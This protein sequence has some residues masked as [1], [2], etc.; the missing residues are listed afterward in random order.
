MN[1]LWYVMRCALL[2]AMLS[3]PVMAQP[4]TWDGGQAQATGDTADP[5]TAPTSRL[6]SDVLALIDAYQQMLDE[7]QQ[8]M[9]VDDLSLL[10]PLTALSEAYLSIGNYREAEIHL[11]QQV[12]LQRMALGLYHANQ[13]PALESLL[14]LHALR[15]DWTELS[16]NLAHIQWLYSRADM[17]ADDRLQGLRRLRGWL[18]LL[19]S[20][21]IQERESIHLLAYHKLSEQIWETALTLYDADDDQLMPWLY[22]LSNAELMIALTIMTNPLAGQDIIAR[23]EGIRDQGV[24]PGQPIATIADLEMAYG[25]RV[26]TV[27]ERSFRSHMH[28]HFQRLDEIRE[29]YGESGNLEAEAIMLIHLGDSVLI[30][31][32]FEG[33]PGSIAGPRRGS[34]AP[35]TAVRYYRDAYKMFLE[36]GTDE[37]TFSRYFGCPAIL[38]IDE[39]HISLDQM[40]P[41][42]QRAEDGYLVLPDTQFIGR[43]IPGVSALPMTDVVP[44][45][46]DTMKSAVA[47]F[48]IARNGHATQIRALEA[49]DTET[50]SERAAARRMISDMQFRPALHQG[51][52]VATEQVRMSFHLP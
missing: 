16:D 15:R 1:G 30:R 12:Q 42:P 6:D 5:E 49:R 52:P 51:D 3:A 31:Q 21:D 32:Q 40:Q 10:E 2:T 24:R 33:R 14:T 25:A 11:N 17:A 13:I 35:G 34:A 29:F 43:V 20:Q 28:R 39:L 7:L 48:N 44:V 8:Q 47:Q 45:D 26:N 23:T 27:Y 37:T 38:P 41:C 22:D 9:G 36:A 18:L 50:A 4:S 19:L 46:I